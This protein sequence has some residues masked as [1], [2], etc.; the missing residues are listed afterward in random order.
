MKAPSPTQFLFWGLQIISLCTQRAPRLG[1]RISQKYHRT[2]RVE[3]LC[4]YVLFQ[5]GH[6]LRLHQ[7]GLH[8]VLLPDCP[9]PVIA[10]ARHHLSA[11]AQVAPAQVYLLGASQDLWR[12]PA[13]AAAAHLHQ[14]WAGAE[15]EALLA[16][17]GGKGRYERK[18]RT[19]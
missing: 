16:E 17:G 5:L 14:V 12:P 10:A 1:G 11:V 8:D 15:R 6:E 4:N 13:G 18:P 19:T 7:C 3:Y 2:A 9:P